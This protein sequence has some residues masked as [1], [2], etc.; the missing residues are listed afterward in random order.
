MESNECENKLY[1]KKGPTHSTLFRLSSSFPTSRTLQT[2]MEK[3]KYAISK[4][5]QPTARK[6]KNE[7]KSLNQRFHN[8]TNNAKTLN[9]T[10]KL[11]KSAVQSYNTTAINSSF[12]IIQKKNHEASLFNYE[13][14]R[15]Y[16]Y[17]PA[18]PIIT[19]RKCNQEND[20]NPNENYENH[21]SSQNSISNLK[22]ISHNNVFVNINRR[23]IPEIVKKSYRS[24]KHQCQHNQKSD[25]DI[26][27]FAKQLQS[28]YCADVLEMSRP[29]LSRLQQS[30]NP[31]QQQK[32]LEPKNNINI[33]DNNNKG[34]LKDEHILPYM[35]R[36]Q[37]KRNDIQ[38][39]NSSKLFRRQLKMEEAYASNILGCAI[40]S[41][42]KKQMVDMKDCQREE[43]V[44]K[45]KHKGN[46]QH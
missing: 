40:S 22:N 45:V 27:N 29:P 31:R 6:N 10:N 39:K 30:H 23:D 5:N 34:A 36:L 11:K 4:K 13:Q 2:K 14:H 41:I 37:L 33:I 46:C 32:Q 44:Q 43:W 20:L 9:Q 35:A 24:Y 25:T 18:R 38:R 7:I 19:N 1:S 21:Y 3:I 15:K 12:G 16:E 17:F 8:V 28:S 42:S 26:P